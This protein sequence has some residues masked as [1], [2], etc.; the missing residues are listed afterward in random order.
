MFLTATALLALDSPPP[1]ERMMSSARSAAATVPP[2]SPI[3]GSTTATAQPT[4]GPAP[5]LYQRNASSERHDILANPLSF[6]S[7]DLT[8]LGGSASSSNGCNI[9]ASK[10][11]VVMPHG[12]GNVKNAI[13]LPF[14]DLPFFKDNASSAAIALA[15]SD[16][17]DATQHRTL[18][19][20]PYHST[21]ARSLRIL[22]WKTPRPTNSQ[23]DRVNTRTAC[24]AHPRVFPAS[25]GR[26]SLRVHGPHAGSPRPHIHSG[27]RSRP[28]AA[29]RP[30]LTY[31]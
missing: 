15:P 4:P 26:P 17:H 19:P 2:S 22:T 10:H 25:H 3:N 28:L 1:L 16:R 21:G 27:S 5:S 30:S 13:T 20:F 8:S 29:P 9:A 14:L 12:L 31:S 7:L 24:R 6:P 11:E 23:N 18:S